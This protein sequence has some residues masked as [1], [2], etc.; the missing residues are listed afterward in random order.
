[1]AVS[2]NNLAYSA[3]MANSV[4]NKMRKTNREIDRTIGVLSS[5]FKI[6]SASDDAAGL[7]VSERMRAE[8]SG[9]A[10]AMENT[11]DGISML[12]TAAGGIS[13]IA[14]II[15]KMR[16]LAVKASTDTLTASDRAMIQTEFGEIRDEITRIS[17][18]TQYNGKKLLNGD[19]AALWSSTDSDVRVIVNGGISELNEAGDR[20]SSE[21]NY[22]ISIRA[23][24]GQAEVQKT[25]LFHL[26][27]DYEVDA[28]YAIE[29]TGIYY[30]ANGQLMEQEQAIQNLG[31][32]SWIYPE[33]GTRDGTSYTFKLINSDDPNDVVEVLTTIHSLDFYTPQGFVNFLN[34]EPETAG[35]TTLYGTDYKAYYNEETGKLGIRSSHDFTINDKAGGYQKLFGSF[36]TLN[37]TSTTITGNNTSVPSS[38]S[39]SPSESPRTLTNIPV[40]VS[41]PPNVGAVSVDGSTSSNIIE[42]NTPG[43]HTISGSSGDNGLS[44]SVADGINT[45][46]TLSNVRSDSSGTYIDNTGISTGLKIG[47]GSN[48]TLILNGENTLGL[49]GRRFVTL[50]EGSTLTIEGNGTLNARFIARNNNK[51]TIN[52]GTINSTFTTSYAGIEVASNSELE[53]NGGTVTARGGSDSAGIGG[54]NGESAGTIT[55]NGGTVTASGG[56]Y[57]AG[58]GGGNGG[59]SGTITITGGEVNATGNNNAAGIGGGYRGSGETITINNGTVTAKGGS[60]A[61]GIGGGNHSVTGGNITINDGTVNAKGGSG[62][63][64][65]GGGYVESGSKVT[66]GGSS[67]S[68]DSGNITINGGNITAIS[69]G[70]GAGIGGGQHMNNGSVIITNGTVN[71]T[72][73]TFGAGIGGGSGGSGGYIEIRGGDITAVNPQEAGAGI[74]SGSRAEGGTVKISGGTIVARGGSNSAGIGSG[75][76]ASAGTI[77]ITSGRVTATGGVNGAGIGSGSANGTA[78]TG[79]SASAGTGNITISGGYIEANGGNNGAGIGGGS[80]A[81]GGTITIS[82]GDIKATSKGGGASI[83]GGLGGLAGTISIQAGLFFEDNTG[84]TKVYNETD[85]TIGYIGNGNF[86]ELGDDVLAEPEYRNTIIPAGSIASGELTL[87]E[88][89]NFYNDDGK[90]LL[91]DP[92]KLTITQGDGKTAS[93]MLYADNTIDEI[94]RNINKAIA[95]DLGQSKYI[96]DIESAFNFAS[97]VDDDNETANA[98]EAVAGSIVIRSAVAGKAGMLKF[99]GNEELLSN[100]GLNTIQEAK[101]NEFEISIKEAHSNK[102]IA[103]MLTTTGNRLVGAVSPNVDLKFDTMTGILVSWND[104]EKKF[105]YSTHSTDSTIHIS[106]NSLNLQAGAKEGERI[107]FSIGEISTESLNLDGLDV[108]SRETAAE[109]ITTIDTA[110]DKVSYQ[111]AKVGGMINRLEHT[112]EALSVMHENVTESESKIRD[113]DMA[114]EYMNFTRLNIMLNARQSVFSQANQMSNNVLTLLR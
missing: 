40:N 100:M 35:N 104:D 54:R 114:R 97:F 65:I 71:A 25:G 59:N 78:T 56:S 91:D 29:G 89:V 62:G 5:S 63:A 39:S 68:V 67:V 77:E 79:D 6:N 7:A 86:V 9:L 49:N 93:V 42:I 41:A 3:S 33:T 83:G 76:F 55:I 36:L 75:R 12:Q 96:D 47:A 108:S 85:D 58:I 111:N 73:Q 21:G 13:D 34:S 57:S 2:F 90:F 94:V 113:A 98:S 22:D 95:Q 27:Y 72:S 80:S 45:T 24:A 23:K 110:L 106:D 38:T 60:S 14:Q 105:T 99:S 26:N 19:A 46:I 101:E 69:A 17:S 74:G 31:F 70:Y 88:I 28:H 52:S 61:A 87:R 92:Q 107:N 109:A 11:Q 16:E 51:I 64:G 4:Y 82:G 20:V 53:I 30:D 43:S 48:V 32:A 18:T 112:V 84:F 66:I 10:R 15:Q 8:M 103:T 1:M 50:G 102:A 37:T 44:I 81:P